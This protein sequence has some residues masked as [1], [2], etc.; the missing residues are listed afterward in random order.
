MAT[1]NGTDGAD[2]ISPNELSPGVTST[3]IRT[4]TTSGDDVI[5][6]RGGDDRIDASFGND[7]AEGGAGNDQVYGNQGDDYLA[8]DHGGDWLIGGEGDDYLNGGS[9]ADTMDGW[10]DD[11]G[12]LVD[13]IGDTVREREAEGND[14]V[15]S[16]LT[17]YTLTDNVEFLN[18]RGN[19]AQNGNGNGLVNFIVGNSFDNV[20][21][22]FGGDDYLSGDGGRDT[23][24]G[25][26]GGDLLIGGAGADVMLGGA[27]NDMLRGGLGNDVFDFNSTAE[28]APGARDVIA[29]DVAPA[30]E[31][32]GVAGG[33]LID[34][35]GIDAN[36]DAGGNQA[37]VFGGTGIGR[38]SVVNSGTDSLVRGNTDRD[39][40]FEFE[41]VIADAG[42]LASAYRAGDFVL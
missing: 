24:I 25:D 28:S 8:G 17:D 38:V 31:G 15:D 1:F 26:G 10:Y 23:L 39:A 4:G 40:A 29:S 42:I 9:G 18:L 33:D 6:G 41:L 16:Y 22:G 21:R 13:D 19:F 37:F 3:P 5:Y 32:V 7:H 36:A 35:S 30:F 27:G 34:L 20:M 11:D 2:I 12:Y 14:Y